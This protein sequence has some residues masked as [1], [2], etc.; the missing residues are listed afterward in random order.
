ME[1]R[2]DGT[3]A[4]RKHD[5]KRNSKS[6]VETRNRRWQQNESSRESGSISLAGKQGQ[7]ER[8]AGK[9]ADADA[10]ADAETSENKKDALILMIDDE[11]ERVR[12]QP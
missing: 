12:V 11:R 9:R 4:L 7:S 3:M 1:G 10:D 2:K 8:E 5:S 6:V